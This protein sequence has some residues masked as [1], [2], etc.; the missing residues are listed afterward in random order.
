MANEKH[1]K[2]TFADLLIEMMPF[3]LSGVNLFFIPGFSPYSIEDIEF[4]S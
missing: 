2:C 1:K 4:P 3:L